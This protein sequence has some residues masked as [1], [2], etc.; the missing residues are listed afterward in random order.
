MRFWL[1]LFA[2]LIFCCQSVFASGDVSQTAPERVFKLSVR[3]TMHQGSVL[4][5]TLSGDLADCS[6]DA[7]F[8]GK[9]AVFSQCGDML[10]ATFPIALDCPKGAY[11]MQITVKTPIGDDSFERLIK[12][13]EHTYGRQQLWLSESQLATYDDP[14]ADKDNNDII[15]ALSFDTGGIVWHKKFIKPTSGPTT[16]VFGLKRFYN[17]DPEPEFHRGVDIAAPAGQQVVASQDGIVRMAKRN[18]KLHGDTVVIDHGRGIGTIY[19]HMNSIN[20]KEGDIVRQGQQIG[21]VGAKGVSTGPHLHWAAY[22]HALPIDPAQLL[23]MPAD[24]AE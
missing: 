16:T 20:V 2:V 5:L 19:I 9:K 14:Q 22:S 21:T 13:E 17:N 7:V 1:L 12:T 23:Q 4:F 18:L 15:S 10:V 3:G 11:K 6:A 24:W 8:R